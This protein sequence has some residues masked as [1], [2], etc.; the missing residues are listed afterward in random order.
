MENILEFITGVARQTG[1]LLLNYYQSNN[2]RATLK[3]DKS[4]V[5]EADLSADRFIAA[6][7]SARFPGEPI[8]SEEIAPTI[9]H[10]DKQVLW[11]VDPLDGTTNF[12][13][14]LPFWGVSIARLTDGYPDIGVLYFPCLEELYTATRGAGAYFNGKR[15]DV[16]PPDPNQPWSFFSCCSRTFRDYDVSIKYKPR[17]LGS[18]AYSCCCVARGISLLSFEATPKVWDFAAGWLLVQE[19]GGVV[20]TLDGSQPFPPASGED[21]SRVYYPI[22]AA[23][24]PDLLEKA[25]KQIRKRI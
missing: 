2:A 21:H 18:A 17:I 4:V 7:I 15:L 25:R 19:A 1:D 24:T 6:Q 20:A 10:T 13:L 16:K 12:S 8:L 3:A 22:L 9:K 23:A 11:V 14:G 5:T